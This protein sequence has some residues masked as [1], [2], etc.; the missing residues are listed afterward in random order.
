MSTATIVRARQEDAARL[1]ALIDALADYEKLPRPEAGARERLLR[2]AFGPRPR[3]EAF[4]AEIED[5]AVGYAV[6]YETYSTFLALPTLYL[7][8]LF[9]L[10][11][12]R[13][14][15]IGR[16]L[17]LHCVREA[18]RR[19]CGRMEW[20][21]LDWNALALGFYERLGA[22]RLSEWLPHRLR[23]EEMERLL[24]QGPGQPEGR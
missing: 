23:R 18:W 1:L 10:P 13:G 20:S 16:A 8:D 11:E 24:V 14:H 12:H 19:Q 7:E 21:V 6:V 4:L 22:G 15:G 2:D 5:G 9:V 17:F 3:F